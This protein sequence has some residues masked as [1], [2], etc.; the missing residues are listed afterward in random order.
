MK[1]VVCLT[2]FN[3]IDC[4]RISME[5][6]KLNWQQTWPVVHACSHATYEPY[7]EDLLLRRPP[8][9]LTTGALD[10]LVASIQSAVERFDPDFVVHLEADTWIMDQQVIIRYLHKLRAVPDSVIAASS[11]SDDRAPA[12][13]RSQELS[14]RA[15]YALSRIL[16]PLGFGYGI[17]QTK[18]ISTQF[19]IA[20]VTPAVVQM[21]TE[22]RARD[23][24]FLEKVL[25]SKVVRH[26]GAKAIVGMPEREPVHPGFRNICE[27]LSLYCQ[28]WPSGEDAPSIDKE[29]LLDPADR[30]RG[31]KESLAAARFALQGPYM[32]RL[33]ESA[34]L[35]YYNGD[36]RRS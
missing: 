26:F 6:I 19:F 9:P 10:L 12:W 32:Q 25:Y 28:H 14:K 35:R 1:V 16:R 21:F 30:P 20:K 3:R 36:A 33:L 4:A 24:D 2:T 13:K 5:I 29:L 15:R 27:A 17:R 23:D 34:D 31:K 7:L 11:W 18:T 8:R 22:L